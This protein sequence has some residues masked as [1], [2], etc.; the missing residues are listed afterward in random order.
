MYERFTE[1]ARKIM[2]SANQRA[3]ESNGEYCETEHILLGLLDNPHSIAADILRNLGS[4]LKQIAAMVRENMPPLGDKSIVTSKPT[5]LPQTPLA[6]KVVEYAIEGA[7]NLK[8]DYLGTEHLLYGLIREAN[9][10]AGQVLAHFG[11]TIDKVRKET[12]SILGLTLLQ[13][14]VQVLNKGTYALKGKAVEDPTELAKTITA[15]CQ[16]LSHLRCGRVRRYF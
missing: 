16:N 10:I 15:L 5:K 7:R 4:D 6:K 8:Q 13:E 1:D 3:C 2:Q 14:G 12:L 9:G 11:I